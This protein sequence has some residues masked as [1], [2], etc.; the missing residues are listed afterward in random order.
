MERGECDGWVNI[1]VSDGNPLVKISVKHKHTHTAYEDI[2][3]PAKWQ[4]FILK[5]LE[6]SP[7]KVRY[8]LVFDWTFVALTTHCED[9]AIYLDT[10]RCERCE[11]YLSAI[12]AEGS[13]LF[14]AQ[15]CANTMAAQ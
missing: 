14:L 4:D 1:F 8:R 3:L 5:N 9:L 12:Q 2:E 15:G 11:E 7:A 13:V 10:R 6:M